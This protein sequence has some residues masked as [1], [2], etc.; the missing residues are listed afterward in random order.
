MTIT[1]VNRTPITF[2]LK[3]TPP[4]RLP[5]RDVQRRYKSAHP[6]QRA[7]NGDKKPNNGAKTKALAGRVAK[8]VKFVIK[9]RHGRCRQNAGKSVGMH[10][11]IDWVGNQTVN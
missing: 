10:N 3:K 9:R 7:P 5:V 6:A 11:D 8:L 4:L 1:D 2:S